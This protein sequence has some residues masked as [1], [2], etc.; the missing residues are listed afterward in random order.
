MSDLIRQFLTVPEVAAAKL[1]T[2]RGADGMCHWSA[3]KFLTFTLMQRPDADVRLVEVLG[4]ETDPC[5]WHCLA[6][7]DG[8]YYDFAYRQVVTLS[9]F[10]LVVSELGGWAKVAEHAWPCDKDPFC[11][12]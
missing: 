1:H 5:L 10:P 9:P 11:L 6:K 3:D 12:V 7:V 8:V 4:H 2:K